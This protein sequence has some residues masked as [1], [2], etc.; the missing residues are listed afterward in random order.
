MKP[1]LSVRIVTGI[2]GYVFSVVL[3]IEIFLH[4]TGLQRFLYPFS[5]SEANE[6]L[7]SISVLQANSEQVTYNLSGG[8]YI[9]ENFPVENF[10]IKVIGIRS[11]DGQMV[12]ISPNNDKIQAGEWLIFEHLENYVYAFVH[13]EVCCGFTHV[14]RSEPLI[15]ISGDFLQQVKPVG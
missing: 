7:Q 9:P 4:I 8:V 1:K 13:M 12:E 15:H 2:I 5:I 11:L 3:I 14:S 6:Y 10:S